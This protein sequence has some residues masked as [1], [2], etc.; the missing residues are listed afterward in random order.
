MGMMTPIDPMLKCLTRFTQLLDLVNRNHDFLT[1][2]KSSNHCSL[3]AITLCLARISSLEAGH[4]ARVWWM[5]DFTVGQKL[6]S[7]LEYWN[8]LNLK[9]QTWHQVFLFSYGSMSQMKFGLIIDTWESRTN[10]MAVLWLTENCMR[11]FR[12]MVFRESPGCPLEISLTTSSS[13]TNSI[14]RKSSSSSGVTINHYLSRR[15]RC[16]FQKANLQLVHIRIVQYLK[17]PS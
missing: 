2:T 9:R 4:T 12:M 13:P 5:D 8:M 15:P 1:L 3:M 6:Q 14:D 17:H 16:L 10:G 7:F 11:A